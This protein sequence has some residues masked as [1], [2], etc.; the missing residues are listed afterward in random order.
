MSFEV[1]PVSGRLVFGDT[2]PRSQPRDNFS[3]LFLPNCCN[4]IGYFFIGIYIAALVALPVGIGIFV[5]YNNGKLGENTS[6]R[7]GYICGTEP[8]TKE[9]IAARNDI[10]TRLYVTNMEGYSFTNKP[11]CLQAGKLDEP[12]VWCNEVR[13][14]FLW[15]SPCNKC[16][17]AWRIFDEID[18]DQSWYKMPTSSQPNNSAVPPQDGWLHWRQQDEEWEDSN[19]IIGSTNVLGYYNEEDVNTPYYNE[20]DINTNNDNNNTRHDIPDSCYSDDI[21]IGLN[22]N[23]WYRAGTILLTIGGI[24][25]GLTLCTFLQSKFPDNGGGEGGT[26]CYC[27]FP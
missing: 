3:R 22:L 20:E 1:D 27:L 11:L 6:Y 17:T 2:Q 8:P 26:I 14:L 19:M 12:A 21:Y 15:W 24:F 9:E 7:S 5:S 25:W 13:P 10:P 16:G 18:N 23:P 4:W